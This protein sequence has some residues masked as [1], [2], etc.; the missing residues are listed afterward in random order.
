VRENGTVIGVSC[1]D[2]A[3]MLVV[4]VY[5]VRTESI[6]AQQRFR[7]VA[8]VCEDVGQRVQNSV[9]ECLVDEAKW[10]KLRARLVKETD[11]SEDSLRFYLVGDNWRHK[12][13]QVG[14]KTTYDPQGLQ[15]FEESA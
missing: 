5:E 14:T 15:R 4:V 6:A 11:L 13:E 8:K 9:F 1:G 3:M 10:T 12:M 7:R 2:E